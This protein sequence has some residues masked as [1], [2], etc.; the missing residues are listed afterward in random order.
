MKSDT[1]IPSTSFTVLNSFGVYDRNFS[2][3]PIKVR[4]N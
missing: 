2:T 4:G 3:G 1:V